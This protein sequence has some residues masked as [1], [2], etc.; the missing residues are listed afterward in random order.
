MKINYLFLTEI[1]NWAQKCSKIINKGYCNPEVDFEKYSMSDNVLK[2]EEISDLNSI[3]TN[4]SIGSW[5]FK[6]LSLS[7][8]LIALLG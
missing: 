5:N 3:F 6:F 4:E 8:P 1:S 2:L 7:V